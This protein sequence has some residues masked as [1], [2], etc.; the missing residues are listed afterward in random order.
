LRCPTPF[1]RAGLTFG[2]EALDSAS[3]SPGPVT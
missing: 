1:F 3:P 2:F